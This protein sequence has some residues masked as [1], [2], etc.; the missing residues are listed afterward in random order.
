MQRH[1]AIRRRDVDGIRFGQSAVLDIPHRHC[2]LAS[3]QLG[4]HAAV[5][6]REM[7]DDDVAKAELFRQIGQ[8]LAQGFQA[9]GGSA[10]ADDERT[11]VQLVLPWQRIGRDCGNRFRFPWRSR[12]FPDRFQID[13]RIHSKRA[14]LIACDPAWLGHSTR[15]DSRIVDRFRKI[16]LA[17]KAREVS[18]FM[19]THVNRQCRSE[20][21]LAHAGTSPE[22]PLPFAL[23]GRGLL[24]RVAPWPAQIPVLFIPV[25]RRAG[26]IRSLALYF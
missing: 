1:V 24:P 8:E 23:Y 13:S 12:S 10:N 20:T 6:R 9:S 14:R 21:S 17:T 15:R 19:T 7:L 5:G 4:H 26:R 16:G 22:S 11:L 18:P 2:R 3:E 25:R